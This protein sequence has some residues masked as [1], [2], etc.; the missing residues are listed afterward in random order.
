M[1]ESEPFGP[2]LGIHRNDAGNVAAGGVWGGQQTQISPGRL[3]LATR[4]ISTGSGPMPNTIGIVVVAALAAR[5]DGVLPGVAITATR[6]CARSAANSGSR[7]L[8]L[9]PKRNSTVT[10]RPSMKPVS[11]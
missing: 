3:R 11:F 2:E 7:A 8:S 6:R 10:L 4:P 1:Q 5:A 9:Y